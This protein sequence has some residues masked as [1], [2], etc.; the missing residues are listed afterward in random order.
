[1]RDQEHR[2]KLKAFLKG[3]SI[4]GTA[5]QI[6]ILDAEI[7]RTRIAPGK[8]PQPACSHYGLQRVLYEHWPRTPK[9]NYRK[10]KS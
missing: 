3:L 9:R 1:M 8:L 6:N 5:L 10:R 4:T 7:L 2:E